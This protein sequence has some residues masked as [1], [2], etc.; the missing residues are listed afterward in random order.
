[1]S[2]RRICRSRSPGNPLGSQPMST[3]VC[4]RGRQ[5]YTDVR[6]HGEGIRVAVGSTRRLAGKRQRPSRVTSPAGAF[7]SPRSYAA[8]GWR[9]SPRYSSSMRCQIDQLRPRCPTPRIRAKM[10]FRPSSR[11][12]GPALRP[13]FSTGFLRHV[14]VWGTDRSAPAPLRTARPQNPSSVDW[15]SIEL[16]E[17]A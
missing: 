10:P 12:F 6:H 17:S 1:M 2:S 9:R 13:G 14:L 8:S 11:P 7:N 16:P 3:R 4:R 5:W 15:P